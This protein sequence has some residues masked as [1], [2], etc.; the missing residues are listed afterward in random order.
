MAASRLWC[1]GAALGLVMALVVAGLHSEEDFAFETTAADEQDTPTSHPTSSPVQRL[2]GIP[3]TV[4]SVGKLFHMTIPGDAF[5][6]EVEHYEARG[7]GGAPLPSWLMFDKTTGIFEG[8]PSVEDLGENYVTVRAF[9]QHSHDWA[10]DVF[11]VD[12][13]ENSRT[14]PSKGAV[15]LRGQHHKIKCNAGEDATMLTVVMDAKYENMKPKQRVAA[16]KNLSGFFSLHHELLQLQPSSTQEDLLGDTVV[17]AGPG[18]VKKRLNKHSTVIQWQV[19]CDGHLW[20]QNSQLVQQLKQQARDGTL[21]EVLQQ[22]VV[23]W[24]VKTEVSSGHRERREIGSGDYDDEA[25]DGDDGDG[26]ED[27]GAESETEAVPSVHIVP[28]MPSPVFPEPTASHPHRHHHGE[29]EP[30]PGLSA[31]PDT[32][33]NVG[34][35]LPTSP[36]LYGGAILPTPV[37]V[38]VRPTHLM[39]SEV[40]VEPSRAYDEF[41]EITPSATPVFVSEV[42]PSVTT[43]LPTSQVTEPLPSSSSSSPSSSPSSSS[44]TSGSTGGSST[45]ESTETSP[46]TEESTPSSTPLLVT[47]EQSSTEK[48]TTERPATSR[49]TE[50]IVFGVKNIQPTIEHRLPKQVAIAGKA[51]RYIIPAD[52]F[53]DLE[54]GNTRNLRLIFKTNEGTAVPAN[55]W[56]QFDPENQEVYGLPLEEH[57]SRWVFVVEAMDREG[58]SV[59]DNLELTVQHHKGRRNVNHEFSLQLRIEKKFDFASSVDW[60]LKV[61]DGLARLYGDPDMSQIVVRTVSLMDANPVIFTWTNET[62]PRNTCPKDDV[63]RLFKVLALNE[64]GDPS[65]ALKE[66]L[67]PSLK[68][69]K[70][71]YKGLHQCELVIGKPQLPPPLPKVPYENYPPIIRNPVDHINATVGR[72]LVFKVPEDTFYDPEDGS[73]RSLKLSLLTMDRSP[74]SSTNWLQF[75]VKNQE[76]YGTPMREDEGR[77]EYQL[78][79]ED[80]GSLT[81]NDGLVV[82][83]HGAPKVQYSV[84]FGMTL[85]MPHE[86]FVNS[87]S[88]K[89]KF[90]EKLKQLFGDHNPDAIALSAISDGSTIV[91]WHNRTLP[92]YHCPE[93]EIRQLRKLLINEDNSITDR[94]GAIM[95]PE[96]SVK[97]IQVMPTGK[98]QGELT[99]WHVPEGPSP[100]GEDTLPIGTSDEYLVTFVVPAVIIA[101]MLILAG[102]VAC[103]LYRRRRTGKMNVGDEDERQSFRNKGIPVIFQDELE[104]RPD[105]GNKSPVIM[106]EEKPPL[107]PPEYQRGEPDH[108]ASPPTAAHPLLG[109]SNASEDPPYQPPPPFTSSR[110]SGRQNRPK[111]TPT[112]RKPPPYVPP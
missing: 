39:S 65:T 1:L 99:V 73:T 89:R 78:V 72:L 61:M 110:D 30:G 81:A 16:I 109:D 71:T 27:D 49:T 92:T 58:K 98:C 85:D 105:P 50:E 48:S 60:Q 24:H 64:D 26:D 56:L 111:P 57:V 13:T 36:V 74:V 69:K 38:P 18:N 93:D 108:P 106:K 3:D 82:V 97:A 94:V 77:R 41:A 76:F 86:S 44:G 31:I 32:V 34:Y 5:S 80:S 43:D 51:F 90:M 83:V 95:G 14:E 102:I 9:G 66:V 68:P 37:L 2:W 21:S 54:D 33:T 91:T 67:S 103:V 100:P 42:E 23:G 55:S 47:D 20:K 96:F 4:A 104:E 62:L 7:P 79:C 25:L 46:I 107:P 17:L 101:A 6:G 52:S 59:S 84:E 75:D 11:S 87:A 29:V 88:M 10:K 15:P 19:G 28:T 45:S 53:S 12:V 112:Y 40:L 63:N 70:V 8:V 35:R 22:P